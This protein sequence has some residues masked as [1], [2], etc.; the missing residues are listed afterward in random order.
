MN[1]LVGCVSVLALSLTRHPM[2]PVL[3]VKTINSI[4]IT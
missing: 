1:V 3:E 4:T 2:V